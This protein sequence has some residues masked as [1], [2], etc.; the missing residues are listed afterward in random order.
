VSE[1]GKKIAVGGSLVVAAVALGYLALRPGETPPEV[2]PVPA[3]QSNEPRIEGL[4]TP[5][6]RPFSLDTIRLGGGGSSTALVGPGGTVATQTVGVGE[7][8]ETSAT[9]PTLSGATVT[10]TPQ[11]TRL[12]GA[13]VNAG[14]SEQAAVRAGTLDVAQAAIQPPAVPAWLDGWYWPTWR[15]AAPAAPEGVLPVV[16]WPNQADA[17][18]AGSHLVAVVANAATPMKPLAEFLAGDHGAAAV[19]VGWEETDHG[20]RADATLDPARAEAVARTVRAARPGL[21][22]WLLCSLTVTGSPE[23]AAA[24]VQAVGPDALVLYGLFARA[25]W[26]TDKVATAN[27]DRGRKFLA[28]K[29]IYAAG[30]RLTGDDLRTVAD[31][32]KRLGW[33]GLVCDGSAR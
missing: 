25:A 1:T 15:G 8:A 22:V 2:A 32:A 24:K 31:R 19:I 9:T 5:T 27:L 7:V 23:Q 21:P 17:V 4:S 6:V 14:G 29:P 3:W 26:E 13:T 33:G 20:F 28:G 10:I 11:A 12:S 18:P 30:Q 16:I